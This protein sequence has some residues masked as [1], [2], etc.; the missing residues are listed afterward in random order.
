MQPSCTFGIELD[1]NWLMHQRNVAR[2][3]P[4]VENA[5]HSILGR[6]QLGIWLRRKALGPTS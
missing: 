5:P 2:N 6:Y 3:A 1:D 4:R